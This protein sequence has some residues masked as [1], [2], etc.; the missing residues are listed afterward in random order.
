LGRTSVSAEAYA[1]TTASTREAEAD[2][3]GV[4]STVRAGSIPRDSAFFQKLLDKRGAAI[5]S[6]RVLLDAPRSIAGNRNRK[7]IEELPAARA[8]GLVRTHRISL[9]RRPDARAAAS[10][11]AAPPSP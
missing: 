5:V 6:R 11:S 10:A 7:Q 1:R 3:E 9:I 8:P 2:S 4:V